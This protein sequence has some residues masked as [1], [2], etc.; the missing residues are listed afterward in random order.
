VP[1]AP[2]AGEDDG[3]LLGF[4]IDV[5]GDGT[6]LEMLETRSIEAAPVASIHGPHR[7]RLGST[8]PRCTLTN[9]TDGFKPDRR[10]SAD[11]TEVRR[12]AV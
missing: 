12:T 3:S 9:G 10:S 5:H 1:R 2:Y 7:I 8:V 4:V 11:W 6:A